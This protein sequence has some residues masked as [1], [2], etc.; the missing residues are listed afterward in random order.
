M[1]T[2]A[3]AGCTSNDTDA[4][5]EAVLNGEA[6]VG[7]THP[8]PG[9]TAEDSNGST[10]DAKSD[11][12]ATESTDDTAA[13]DNTTPDDDSA[14]PDS[15]DASDD[16]Q[17][18]DTSSTTG[19][20]NGDETI[21]DTDTTQDP[22]DSTDVTNTGDT[23]S[24]NDA[25]DNPLPLDG[26]TCAER[27]YLLCESFEQT[28]LEAIPDGWQKLG[29]EISVS[30]EQAR[31]GSRSLKVG[32][33]SQGERRIAHDA[34]TLSGTHWGRLYYRVETAP[35]A[36]VHSTMVALDGVG[37][38]GVPSEYRTL[39]TVKHD[40]ETQDVGGLHNWI[41]HVQRDPSSQ[42]CSDC[43]DDDCACEFGTETGYDWEFDG[44]WHCIEYFVDSSTQAYRFFFDGTERLS[45]TG[46]F[47][48]W[49]GI[50]YEADLPSEYETVKVG[51]NNY[52]AA[53]PGFEVYIDDVV[54][55]DE[56]IGCEE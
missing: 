45:F 19:S 11:A 47:E 32:Q 25:T 8:R 17:A 27:D 14:L 26:D 22:D 55:D 12:G 6:G 56:R 3:I 54:F 5:W 30:D 38:A 29:D 42:A 2:T 4:E 36:F 53:P 39:G 33:V 1:A 41:F 20:D 40:V 9:D 44:E 16:T 51:W 18:D 48:D 28:P 49:Q 35:D 34:S 46:S 52:S 24:T 7:E 50:E 31:G 15:T 43:T 10:N 23:G 37:P 13:T 21:L